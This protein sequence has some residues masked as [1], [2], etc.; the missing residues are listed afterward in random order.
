MNI[1]EILQTLGIKSAPEEHHHRTQ[2]FEQI[3]CPWCS[4]NT[5][6]WR[7][8]I[9]TDGRSAN[10]WSCGIHSPIETLTQASNFSLGEVLELLRSLSD[11]IKTTSRFKTRGKL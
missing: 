10:C 2:S 11:P 3:D 6:R 7:L 4:P 8:G 1:Q 9:S 5:N